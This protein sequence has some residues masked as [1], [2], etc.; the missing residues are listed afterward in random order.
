MEETIQ[1]YLEGTLSEKALKEFEA[2]LKN[3]ES[4]QQEVK[5]YQ[6]LFEAFT[7]EAPTQPSDRLAKN[8]EKMLQEEKDNQ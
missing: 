6:A 5:D 2:A 8:F 1:K 4:L 7:Q 3:S